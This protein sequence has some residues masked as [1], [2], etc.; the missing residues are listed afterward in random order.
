MQIVERLAGIWQGDGKGQY[1]TIDTFDYLETLV[2][3]QI[4]PMQLRYLQETRIKSTG[5]ASHQETG[6]LLFGMD[7]TVDMKNVQSND[8]IEQMTGRWFEEHRVLTLSLQSQV[9]GG[10]DRMIAS[11]REFHLENGV[12]TYIM[13]MQTTTTDTKTMLFHLEGRLMQE[14]AS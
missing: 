14:I 9:Y 6:Y 7:G 13:H 10:D 8:R 4:S 1:P 11:E 12:L 2:F 5:K 3:T